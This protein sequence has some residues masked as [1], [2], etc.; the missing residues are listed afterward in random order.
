MLQ[1]EVVA[2]D[3]EALRLLGGVLRVLREVL[4]YEAPARPLFHLRPMP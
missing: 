3:L 1:Y 2:L 4:R